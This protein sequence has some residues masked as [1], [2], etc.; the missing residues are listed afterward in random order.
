MAHGLKAHPESQVTSLCS[1]P[2]DQHLVK[3][4]SQLSGRLGNG[5][6]LKTDGSGEEEN[7]YW[8]KLVL[9]GKKGF[10]ALSWI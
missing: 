5:A 8:G 1:L 7:G 10:C 4:Q 6:Q 9:S 2:V 3:G